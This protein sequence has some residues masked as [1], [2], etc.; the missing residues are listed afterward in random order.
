V[1]P[2]PIQ[3]RYTGK[4]DARQSESFEPFDTSAQ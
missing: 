1:Y 4:G 2:Y 3:A